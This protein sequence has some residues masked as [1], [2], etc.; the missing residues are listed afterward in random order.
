M[1]KKKLAATRL[2]ETIQKDELKI[3]QLQEALKEK[4]ERLRL[5]Q[6]EI[7]LAVALEMAELF[8]AKYD[9]DFLDADPQSLVDSIEANSSPPEEPQN[10]PH[11]NDHYS[12]H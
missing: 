6:D 11:Q 7:S 12:Q 3:K 1:K 2:S 10:S 5:M 9:L 4:K 8:R